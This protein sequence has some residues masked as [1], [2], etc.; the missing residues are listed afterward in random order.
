MSVMERL[1][2]VYTETKEDNQIN[3]VSTVTPNILH[4]TIIQIAVSL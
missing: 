4:D 2:Y 1:Y 3:D